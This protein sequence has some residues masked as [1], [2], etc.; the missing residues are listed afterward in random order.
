MSK[1]GQLQ[2]LPEPPYGHQLVDCE[3]LQLTVPVGFGPALLGSYVARHA[4]LEVPEKHRAGK[5]TPEP[6]ELAGA[7]VVTSFVTSATTEGRSYPRAIKL[8]P[9]KRRAM[10]F[11][12]GDKVRFSSQGGRDGAAAEITLWPYVVSGRV[13][14]EAPPRLLALP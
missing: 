3:P 1:E 12:T 10:P 13:P 4:G 8:A 6:G 5:V 14:L 2:A 9:W 7:I 11:T